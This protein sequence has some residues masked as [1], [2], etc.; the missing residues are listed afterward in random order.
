MSNKIRIIGVGLAAMAGVLLVSG[1]AWAQAEETPISFL[2]LSCQN[3]A[4]PEREWVDEDG[5]RHTRDVR[6]RCSRSGQLRGAE[7]G[8]LSQD[9]DSAGGHR[10]TRAYYSFNGTVLGN[11]ATGVGRVTE[12]CDRIGG[13]WV[14]T[15]HDVMQ[16]HGGGLV[17]TTSAWEGG[18]NT[19]W[20]GVLL[21]TPGGAKRNGPRS[22]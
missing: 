1:V 16:L 15:G 14:C 21:E 12:E 4:E 10:F 9:I 5:I 3:L 13:V 8:W 6:Y 17:K 11:L 22:K 18:E 2:L 7:I 20:T 19:P